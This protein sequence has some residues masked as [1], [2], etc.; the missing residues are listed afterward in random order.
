MWSIDA[1]QCYTNTSIDFPKAFR[2]K[3]NVYMI[4]NSVTRHYSFELYK[5]IDNIS[6]TSYMGNQ[7]GRLHEKG[8]CGGILGSSSCDHY[9]TN[10]DTLIRFIW[11]DVISYNQLLS[12]FI[13][14]KIEDILIIGS[15]P[16][17][18][19]TPIGC[20]VTKN[21]TTDWHD[22]FYSSFYGFDEE[23]YINNL[24]KRLLKL[25]PG[26]IIWHSYPYLHT[27]YEDNSYPY[28][29][30]INQ[31]RELITLQIKCMIQKVNHPR[32]RFID[33]SHYLSMHEEAYQDMIHHHGKLSDDVVN[34]IMRMI[35]N[36]PL[37]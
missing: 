7:S 33:V 4:G 29:V 9:T 10:K 24:F 31:C 14:P 37:L 15:L 30:S 27:Q 8:L 32:L 26:I 13:H 23:L 17:G 21:C 2:N 18:N 16:K 28:H 3:R 36:I 1:S 34:M 25:F 5:M 35:A 6:Y 19:K 22:K 11:H 12:Y 20:M